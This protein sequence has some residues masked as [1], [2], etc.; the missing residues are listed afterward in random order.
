MRVQLLGDIPRKRQGVRREECK[1]SRPLAGTESFDLGA[2]LVGFLLDTGELIVQGFALVHFASE[3]ARDLELPSIFAHFLGQRG[4]V[5][6][7]EFKMTE[8]EVFVLLGAAAD[9]TGVE[10][11]GRWAAG[12]RV[13]TGLNGRE[14]VG[15]PLFNFGAE[16]LSDNFE[17]LDSRRLEWERCR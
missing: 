16:S 3:S 5:L 13:R 9:H 4:P 6:E 12:M 14:L 2:E 10:P 8:A 17:V 1:L 11:V 15:L 7:G